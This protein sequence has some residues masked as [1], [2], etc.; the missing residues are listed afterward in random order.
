V[1]IKF[2]AALEHWTNEQVLNFLHL[3]WEQ[4][5]EDV[6]EPQ[7]ENEIDPLQFLTQAGGEPVGNSR[8]AE[9]PLDAS[10]VVEVAKRA[11]ESLQLSGQDGIS[12]EIGATYYEPS[13]GSPLSEDAIILEGTNEGSRKMSADK[14]I[15]PFG[16][17][18]SNGDAS[19]LSPTDPMRSNH[20]ASFVAA[21]SAPTE[22][23]VPDPARKQ[24]I[25][26][27]LCKNIQHLNQLAQLPFNSTELWKLHQHYFTPV[28]NETG[29]APPSPSMDDMSRM[30]SSVPE[31]A[32]RNAASV[33]PCTV[34]TS[35]QSSDDYLFMASS[36]P[37]LPASPQGAS[38]P[39]LKR[40]VSYRF[41]GEA[42][43]IPHVRP[44]GRH[45]NASISKLIEGGAAGHSMPPKSKRARRNKTRISFL[46]R[47]KVRKW[48]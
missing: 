27:W 18:R 36:D 26:D 44:E 38:L 7:G 2:P 15:A 35:T 31:V 39:I 22:Q 34:T 23:S 41:L 29:G 13:F 16:L 48:D 10:I 45:Q 11:F 21:P 1:T 20:S 43:P 30:V 5:D 25:V 19:R 9:R 37:S 42:I 24:R 4:T 40:K 17:T 8:L 47:I 46:P 3:M 14:G 33:E 28:V 32:R 6:D 12:L